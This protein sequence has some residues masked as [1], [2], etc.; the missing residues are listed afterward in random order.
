MNLSPVR[1]SLSAIYKALVL[2]DSTGDSMTDRKNVW[3]E[4]DVSQLKG[5]QESIRLEFKAGSLFDNKPQQTWVADL[6]KEVSAFANTEG[7]ALVLG[8]TEEKKGKERVAGD[9]DG[10]PDSVPTDQLQRLIE[11]NVSPYLPGIRVHRVPLSSS[12]GRVVFVVDVPQGATAYQANDGRYYGR[13]ELEAKYLPD[14]EIRL[15]MA[16]G[17]VAR[18][19]VHLRLR[20]ITLGKDCEARL[21]DEHRAALEAF[22]AD[23]ATAIRDHPEILDLMQARFAP[24]VVVFELSLRNDGEITIREPVLQLSEQRSESLIAGWDIQGGPLPARLAMQG[25][26]IYPGDERPIDG[27]RCELRCKR[28]APLTSGDYAVHWKVFL[29]N[30]P[31]SFGQLD[32]ADFIQQARAQA[33]SA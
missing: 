3:T 2:T 24:D 5:R 23:A 13:S 32:L 22:R 16:R 26:V 1:R 21:R 12:P 17:R 9:A 11:G 25:D 7:G 29:D 20:S 8:V 6:A 30:S 15:R 28:D 27:S 18:A 14:H 4:E 33:A 19:G 10:V 31:P